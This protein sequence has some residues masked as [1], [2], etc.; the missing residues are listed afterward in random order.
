MD[1]ATF[2]GNVSFKN[3]YDE[4]KD[5]KEIQINNSVGFDADGD[6][7][8]ELVSIMLYVDRKRDKKSVVDIRMLDYDNPTG[9]LE[10]GRDADS[11]VSEKEGTWNQVG[12]TLSYMLSDSNS[13][14]KSWV[15]SIEA[16][17]ITIRQNRVPS[18]RTKI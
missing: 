9:E 11:S 17:M 16:A 7:T 12:G 15:W 14:D 6:G 13:D 1:N 3:W 8:D 10:N 18:E 2:G 5:S 4:D